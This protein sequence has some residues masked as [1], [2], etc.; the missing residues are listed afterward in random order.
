MQLDPSYILHL[1]FASVGAV[2]CLLGYWLAFGKEPWMWRA[3][4]VCAALALLVP[5]R[6]YEPLVFFGLISLFFLVVAGGQRLFT[7]FRTRRIMVIAPDSNDPPVSQRFQFRLH[8]LL[9]LMAV[10]GAV[11]WMVR[12]LLREQVT[13]PWIGTFLSVAVAVAIT[14]ATIGLLRG[15]RRIVWGV[16]LTLVVGVAVPYFDGLHRSGIFPTVQYI[17]GSDLGEQLFWSNLNP[18][19]RLLVLILTFLVF[20][21]I[22][23]CAAAAIQ[24]TEVR[25]VF[26]WKW[27]VLGVVPC[28]AWLLPA[29]W[30]YLQLLSYP[31]PPA[32]DRDRPNVLPRLLERGHNLEF[33]AG[34]PQAQSVNAEVIRLSKEPGFVPVPW[35]ADLRARRHYENYFTDELM[36]A[37]SISRGLDAQATAVE[38]TEPDLA[39]EHVMAIFRLGDKLEHEGLLV[40]GLVGLAIDGVGQAHLTKLRQGVSP[41][42]RHKIVLELQALEKS[43]DHDDVTRDQLWYSLNDRWAFR[44]DQVLNPGT[45]VSTN[46][47]YFHYARSCNRSIC[48]TRLLMIDLAVRNYHT[49]HG[50]H[51]PEL[52]SLVP[53][54]LTEIP[55][56]PFSQKPF[57]YYPTSPDFVLYSVGGDGV[58]N[59][60]K[61]GPHQFIPA[62]WDGY[63]LNLDAPRE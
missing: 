24:P 57:I 13:M 61:F 6:A 44:L 22:F 41:A 52:A 27:R 16:I 10:F 37:R 12:T 40:H 3:G 8:D 29:T 28:L 46:S 21:T 31:Q 30:L 15:P 2:Y 35:N 20:L 9:G 42:M 34:L 26:R 45:A 51:P 38:K 18:G 5:I 33:L 58:D 1:T 48:V 53:Q 47:N 59:G 25:P 32:V 11:A 56:D 17:I 23:Y 60:G 4:A 50:N 62:Y 7:W 63:D 14:L 39:A 19:V 43:R 36:A 55:L 49:D 54:Y